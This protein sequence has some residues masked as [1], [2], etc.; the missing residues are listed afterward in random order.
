MVA[1]GAVREAWVTLLR[2]RLLLP[3]HTVLVQQCGLEFTGMAVSGFPGEAEVPTEPLEF[4]RTPAAD[5][6]P[7]MAAKDRQKQTLV[8]TLAAG[9][10]KRSW[11][12]LEGAEHFE[13]R[14]RKRRGGA[15]GILGSGT[16]QGLPSEEGGPRWPP[17]PPALHRFS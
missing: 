7:V 11:G 15:P 6:F 1:R 3:E 8:R 13:G 17:Q 14:L 10:G 12:R 4:G 16:G 9:S 2:P 5:G